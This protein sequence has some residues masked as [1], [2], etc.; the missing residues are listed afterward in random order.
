M[1]T[2]FSSSP[3]ISFPRHNAVPDTEP[4]CAFGVAEASNAAKAAA[5]AITERSA[6]TIPGRRS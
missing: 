1:T 2:T 5:T 4:L 6:L 3:S